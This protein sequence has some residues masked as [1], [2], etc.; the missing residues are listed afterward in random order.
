M[1]IARVT[2]TTLLYGSVCQNVWHFLKPDYVTA[3]LPVLLTNLRDHWLDVYKNMIIAECSFISL[4]AEILASGGAGDTA[5]LLLSMVGGSGNDV[6][7]PLMMS[8]VIQLKTGLSGRKNR[9]RIFVMGASVGQTL[10]GLFT[11][12]WL[13]TVGGYLSTLQGRWCAASPTYGWNLVIHGKND[14]PSSARYVVTMQARSTPGT[15][16]RREL[17]VGV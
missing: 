14:S 8:L 11:G 3:D 13:G 12:S 16:R 15:Q 1:A 4:H 5:D 10:S 17:G 2:F 6:R 7:S 9:G